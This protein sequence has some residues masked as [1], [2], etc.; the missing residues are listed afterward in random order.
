MSQL[1]LTK[2]LSLNVLLDD[3][4]YNVEMVSSAQQLKSKVSFLQ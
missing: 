1:S 2:Y 4:C 3:D